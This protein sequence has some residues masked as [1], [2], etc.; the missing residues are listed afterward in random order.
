VTFK[1]MLSCMDCHSDYVPRA[2][3]TSLCHCSDRIPTK[4]QIWWY[5]L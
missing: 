2:S 4:Y 5:G 3:P 1:F